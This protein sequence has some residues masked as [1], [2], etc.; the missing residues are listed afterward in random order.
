[1]ALLQETTPIDEHPGGAACGLVVRSTP[2]RGGTY[3]DVA[4]EAGIH[5]VL[6]PAVADPDAANRET[7][8]LRRLGSLRIDVLAGHSRCEIR[9]VGRM[10]PLSR[11]ISSGAAL[12]LIRQGVPTMLVDGGAR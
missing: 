6:L 5:T 9:G 10:S 1:M 11:R 12:S 2:H 4:T 3:L 7:A 8:G